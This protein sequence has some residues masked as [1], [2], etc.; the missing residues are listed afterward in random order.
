VLTSSLEGLKDRELGNEIESS[1]IRPST[2]DPDLYTVGGVV[3]E[4]IALSDISGLKW[5]DACE[6]TGPFPLVLQVDVR[7]VIL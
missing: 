5:E 2:E 1:A 7:A 4:P 3:L 6:V